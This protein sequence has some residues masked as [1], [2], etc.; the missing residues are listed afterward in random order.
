MIIDLPG[1]EDGLAAMAEQTSLPILQDTSA[2]AVGEM[3][4]GAR[5]YTMVLDPE[6][7]PT[8]IFYDLQFATAA[9]RLLSEVAAAGGRR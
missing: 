5:D 2:A 8:A 3:L 6:G 7:H 4:G 9:D 1:Y